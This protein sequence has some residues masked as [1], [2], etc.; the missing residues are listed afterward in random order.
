MADK[1]AWLAERFEAKRG[2]G[3]LAAPQLVR[4]D[5]EH[6]HRLEVLML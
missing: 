3:G 4:Y 2:P 5:P 6:L 1:Q